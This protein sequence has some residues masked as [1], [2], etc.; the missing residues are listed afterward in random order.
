LAMQVMMQK[1]G[2]FDKVIEAIDK[3]VEDLRS[4]EGDDLENKEDCEST[5]EE[6][7]AD[8]RKK[9]L[10]VDDQSDEITRQKAII[11]EVEEQIKLKEE[12]IK[13][14]EEDIK[15][16]TRQREDEAAAYEINDADDKAAVELVGKAMDVLKAFRTD[17]SLD[18]VQRKA[19]QEPP[20]VEAGK[21]PPPPPATGFD[22]PYGGAKGESQGIQAML[23]MI[24]DDIEKDIAKA[25]KAEED[26]KEAFKKM[27][28]DAEKA[29]E[30]AKKSNLG[31]RGEK[32]R[33]REGDW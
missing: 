32:S 12:E 11:K 5:R 1:K 28:E 27:K 10:E 4:E 30:A 15:E 21:A 2:H 29:I 8:A 3:M 14:L 24:K 9:S 23:G 31:L 20:K 16:A 25:D 18:L 22:E 26:A 17:N 13:Q 7:T 6:E 19:K 33:G